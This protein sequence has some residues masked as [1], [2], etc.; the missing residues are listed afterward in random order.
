MRLILRLNSYDVEA[1]F[2]AKFNFVLVIAEGE[3]KEQAIADW[4]KKH[5]RQKGLRREGRL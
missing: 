3:F 5:S 1:S 2:D 4:L